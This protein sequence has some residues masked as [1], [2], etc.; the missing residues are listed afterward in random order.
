M[1]Y[2]QTIDYLFH[3]LPMF[4]RLGAAA[5]KKDIT[6][7]LALS[8]LLGN[9]HRK[10]KSIHIAG[11][12]GKGSTSHMLA[13][14]LHSAGYKTGLYTSPHL[15][16]FRE[17]IRI[18]GQMIPEKK[19]VEF[20][21]K[22]QAAIESIEPSFFEI[23]VA[24]AFSWF[25]ESEID[26][27]VVE[28]GL[29]GK[30]DSTNIIHPDLSIITN[31]SYDHMDLLGDTIEKIAYEK[32]GI[33]KKNTP[34]VI[35]EEQPSIRKVFLEVAAAHQAPIHFASEKRQVY[36]WKFDRNKLLVEVTDRHN[37]DKKHFT[38]DLPGIY[39]TKNIVTVLEAIAILNQRGYR[40][41]EQAVTQGLQKVK[42][43]TGLHGR[44]EI[45][46]ER[47]LII[48]DVG[49]NEEGIKE[50]ARQIEITAHE[51]LHIVIGMVKD[52]AVEKIL[53][54]LPAQAHFYFT[55]AQIPR[56]L[57]EEELH[58]KAA[59][60]GLTGQ[61]YPDVQHALQ[62]AV[63]H[64]HPDD[65]ILVCGSVFVAGEVNLSLISF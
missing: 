11:T 3:R 60:L 30:L 13:A 65:L 12:N 41:P 22:M 28:V 33:I 38:L 20:T 37:N 61:H 50:I 62:A 10:F 14:V 24:M 8:E 58:H 4:G 21:E 40:I 51:E 35:G 64:A 5:Y 2:I 23:T 53:V 55:K 15:Y 56:A 25:A 7:I 46:H 31:I 16:D 29:G 17:R 26:V 48:L 6:N 39:Q 9:P 52:K 59:A 1:D 36:D 44:W 34:V 27:A 57:P 63:T 47:P 19:V 42:R 49:H 45:L 18:D 54:Q 43:L 32:A